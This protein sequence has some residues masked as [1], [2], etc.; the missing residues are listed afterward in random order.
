MPSATNLLSPAWTTIRTQLRDLS[1]ARA[2][3]KSL[4]RELAAYTTESDLNDFGAILDRYSEAETADIRRI[5]AGLPTEPET[6]R[7]PATR[8]TR[9]VTSYVDAAHR[10]GNHL[11]RDG[12]RSLMVVSR[13]RAAVARVTARPSWSWAA[14]GCRTC[15]GQRARPA[16]AHAAPPPGRTRPRRPRA[17][18]WPA[19]SPGTREP[20]RSGPAPGRAARLTRPKTKLQARRDPGLQQGER[21]DGSEQLALGE[22]ER[23]HHDGGAGRA[24]RRCRSCPRRRRK[25]DTPAGEL[26]G[27]LSRDCLPSSPEP[28]SRTVPFGSGGSQAAVLRSS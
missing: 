13:S 10:H 24:S 16:R 5:L 2:A 12:P 21:V 28:V 6:G 8:T 25:G 15:T 1:A 19:R 7:G 17:A 4:E 3:N 18:G 9:M 11:R 22:V 23:R 26:V 20:R 14:A 27:C